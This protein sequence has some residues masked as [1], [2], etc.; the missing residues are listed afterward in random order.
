[1]SLEMD[2][3]WTDWSI[4]KNQIEE[5]ETPVSLHILPGLDSDPVTT[6]RSERDWKDT[7][8][9]RFGVEY[10]LNDVVTIRG[11][12]FYDPTP[13]PDHTLDL[14]W[15]DADK[16]TYS[17]GAGFNFATNM[18]I[19]AVVQYTDIEKDREVGGESD[20]LNH[21]YSDYNVHASAGGNLYGAGMTFTYRF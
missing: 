10:L 2:L 9:L 3:V 21:S 6:L 15:P 5:L 14:Q 4:N 16:K 17:L 7:K 12:Y 19:D 11:G 13:I 1:M 18:S 20:N 8:Q